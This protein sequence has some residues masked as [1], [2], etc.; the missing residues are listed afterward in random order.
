MAALEELERRTA[1]RRGRRQEEVSRPLQGV[2][3]VPNSLEANGWDGVIDETS[4]V[5]EY[6]RSWEERDAVAGADASDEESRVD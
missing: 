6:D 5:D 3:E 1:R 2:D 4:D